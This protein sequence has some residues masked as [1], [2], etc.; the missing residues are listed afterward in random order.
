VITPIALFDEYGSDAVRYWAASARLGTDAAFDTGQMKIG[1]RLAIKLLNAAKFALTLGATPD[2]DAVTHPLDR[3]LIAGLAIVV[4][5]A[6][7]AFGD[8]NH[9]RALE[10][11]ETFFWTFCDDYVELVKERAYGTNTEA[12]ASAKAALGTALDVLLRL[13]APFMPYVTEEVWSWWR[14][15]SIHRSTWPTAEEMSLTGVVGTEPTLLRIVGV[16]LS[17]VRGAKSTAQ[18][19]MRTPV[20][21][22]VIRGTSADLDL[23]RLAVDDLAATGSIA[24][25]TFE[26]AEG[27]ELVVD[28]TL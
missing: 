19:S 20:S 27:G 28:V 7:R 17:Q 21:R 4:D 5:E 16:A 10:V 8:Y 11:S 23:L 12:A 22:A 13:F 9:T 18:V 15:G 3:S 14:E 26:P 2:L 25:V 1:R 24:E 6:T